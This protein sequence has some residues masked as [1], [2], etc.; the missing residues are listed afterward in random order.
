LISIAFYLLTALLF[1]AALLVILSK[2]PMSSVLWMVV[3]F[4]AI[5]GHYVLL[6]AQFLV[7]VNMVVY[8]GAIMVLFIYTVMLLNLNKESDHRSTF[9]V[10]LAG[11]VSGGLLLTVLVAALR[12]SSEAAVGDLAEVGASSVIGLVKPLGLAL[13]RDF[14]VPFEL[15]SALFLA[16]LVGAVALGKKEAS[17]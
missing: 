14:L 3:A 2:N 1:S 13:F 15:S 9:M 16:A 6:N 12:R 10:R 7:V 8:A 4:F 17:D 11:I 5:T